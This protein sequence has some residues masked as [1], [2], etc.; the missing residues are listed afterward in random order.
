MRLPDIRNKVK[1]K[2]FTTGGINPK[3]KGINI[4]FVNIYCNI[5]RKTFREIKQ[6]QTWGNIL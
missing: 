6:K 4:S 1:L 3:H 2:V 5:G